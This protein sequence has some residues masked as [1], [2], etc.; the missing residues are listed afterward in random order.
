MR[1]A[2]RWTSLTLFLVLA[3]TPSG[4]DAP[5]DTAAAQAEASAGPATEEEHAQYDFP[6]T[7]EGQEVILTYDATHDVMAGADP[8]IRRVVF[9]HHGAGQNPTTYFESMMAALEAADADRPELGL[10]EKTLVLS[11]AMIGSDHLEDLP[12]RYADGTYAFWDGGWR[13]GAA[14]VSDPGVSNFHLLDAL[15]MHVAEKFP[16]VESLVYIGH[17]AGGQLVSR[18]SVGSPIHDELE[19]RGIRVRY[20]I[21]NPSSVLYFDRQRPDLSADSG[22]IDY[23]D[24]VPVVDGEAC[25]DF[26]EYKYGWEDRVEYMTRRPIEDMLADFQEREVILFQ[27]TADNDPQGGGLDRD[28]PGLLQGRFRLERGQRYHEYLGHFFGPD[29]YETKSIVLVPDVGHSSSRMFIS[30]PGKRIIFFEMEG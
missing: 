8:A 19:G 21:A 11:P 10:A 6:V 5:E 9:V 30:E 4:R 2:C 28:C 26:N 22:F 3:C 12:S 16:N 15:S 7:V 25:T 27:G 1:S 13:E 14:S 20:I 29:V 24:D 23:T 17:S 18:Y